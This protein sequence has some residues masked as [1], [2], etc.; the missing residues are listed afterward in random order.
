LEEVDSIVSDEK[1]NRSEF[2]RQ[3]MKLYI[4]QRQKME[5]KDKMK[6][7]YEEMAVINLKFAEMCI[8]ADNEI[9]RKYEKRLAE[10]E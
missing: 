4:K 7:G 8:Q 2:I 5:M 9:Y 1:I 10:C 6:K 3:A